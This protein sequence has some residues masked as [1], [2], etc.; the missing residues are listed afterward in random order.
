VLAAAQRGRPSLRGGLACSDTAYQGSGGDAAVP[1]TG[2]L[3]AHA[4]DPATG[5]AY[6]YPVESMA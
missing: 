6:L 1:W 5:G 2:Y 4:T 3:A